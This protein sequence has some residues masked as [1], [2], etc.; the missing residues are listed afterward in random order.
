[1]IPESLHSRI[2]PGATVKPLDDLTVNEVRGDLHRH[3]ID[4]DNTTRINDVPLK[5]PALSG[6]N[7]EEHFMQ[8]ANDQLKPY[9]LLVEKLL[10]G[11]VPTMPQSWSYTPGW[12]KYDL[13]P[14]PVE[15]P[16]EAALVF[17]VE[18]C[19]SAGKSPTMAT[20]V[21]GTHW[22]S[23]CSHDLTAS[24]EDSK[25]KRI[26]KDSI[27]NLINLESPANAERYSDGDR[28]FLEKPKIVIGH[29]V[30]YDRARIKE[31]YWLE[32]TG[33]RFIDTMSL[34]TCVSGLTSYQRAMLKSKS[35]ELSEEDLIWSSQS[36]L[37]NLGD[38]YKLYCDK[39]LSKEPRNIF[40]EGTMDD[41]HDN[42]QKLMHY[43][44]NDV[45][46]TLD[47]LKQ[48]F[49]L[50]L[51]RFPHPATL[52]GMLEIG[53]AYLPINNNWQRYINE[54]DLTFEELNIEAKHL[55]SKR[56]DKMCHLMHDEKYKSNL[57]MWDEDW[58]TKDFKFKKAAS[59]KKSVSQSAVGG[60]T[61][62]GDTEQQLRNKFGHLYGMANQ[63]PARRPL[64]PGYPEWYRKL[65]M[66][67]KDTDW[68]PGAVNLS[69]GMQIAPKILNLCWEGYP[70][71]YI[72]EHGWGF[73]VPHR[74]DRYCSEEVEA[75][76]PLQSL[77][78]KCP[79][80][81]PDTSASDQGSDYEFQSLTTDLEAHLSKKDYYSKVKKNKTEGTYSGSG[82]FCNLNLE[83]CCWFMKLPHKDGSSN[84]VGNP[85]AKTFITKFSE[86]VLTGEGSTAQRVIEIAKMVSYWR[87][88]C[89]RIKGQL[90]IW[91]S[92]N[93]LPD[94]LQHLEMDYGAILPQVVVSGTLTRRAVESTWM[95]ASNTLKDRIGSE[96][97]AMIQAPR[98]YKIVGA[99]VDSQELWIASILGDAHAAGVHGITPLG[100]MTLSGSKE[101][102]T[103]MHSVTAKAV[104]I[105]R[106]HAK[107]IN[108]ARIYGA[109]QNFAESLLKQYNPSFSNGEARSK[110]IKMFAITKGKKI[111]KLRPEYHDQFPDVPYA[112]WDA[113][114]LA[115]ANQTPV[116]DF[117]HKPQWEGGSESAMFNRLEEI[118]DSAQPRTPFL[119]GRLSRAL[120]PSERDD[121]RFLPTRINWVVQSGAVDFLH[122]MLVCM[123]WLMGNRI[124][125]SLSFHDE[126]RYLVKDEVA[127]KTALALHVTNLLTR[128]F[129]ASRFDYLQYTN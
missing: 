17:D 30:S 81:G 72:R 49:P 43:C 98:G 80:I 12:T 26:P 62:S 59:K 90:T 73:L 119:N 117:F 39:E 33:L 91:L 37:N 109:G 29:N 128:S 23:W 51:E 67:L 97:R 120:E 93:Q 71:H 111:Y 16:E 70:L 34:H 75:K 77:I 112:V 58:S 57:W 13:N 38:V 55:L 100:W 69:T 127:Y 42:F 19:M 105:S 68:Q 10:Q 1:M 124:R 108:Y 99:D 4:I 28:T 79:V 11:I 22:Y 44:A 6:S 86:N 24:D 52:A 32:S 36:S 89:D 123:R 50:F 121:G 125:F 83:N 7:I 82:I 106:D 113:L 104:G 74:R 9:R 103:D 5:L 46:A 60:V 64:L 2:F 41:I 8:I 20:A 96:L 115:K 95:T 18:V 94:E 48:L 45:L 66:K 102:Q 114:K 47:I 118:A 27:L 110:A 15:F 25:T 101:T 85:L 31:Q 40:V 88:N 3:G 65:C 54:A 116:A 129:C 53:Q 87:N 35:K 56:A 76:I 126:I 78:E 107:V 92:K 61:N 63:L 122:L 21:S 14:I 84:R